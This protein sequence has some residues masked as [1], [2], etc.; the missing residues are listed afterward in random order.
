MLVGTPSE[1]VTSDVDFRDLSW[2][3]DGD[4]MTLRL[5]R[6]DGVE[7]V[8]GPYGREMVQVWEIGNEVNGG[9]KPQAVIVTSA[10]SLFQHV[11]RGF[12]WYVWLSA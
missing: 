11:L 8:L 12:G 1:G 4:K 5:K 3:V 6:G 2:A 10:P 9:V 7:V